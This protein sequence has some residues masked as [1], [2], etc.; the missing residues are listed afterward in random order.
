MNVII[1]KSQSTYRLVVPGDHFGK[2][3]KNK[4]PVIELNGQVYSDT[5]RIVKLLKEH[6]TDIDADLSP[7][8]QATSLAIIRM[9][10]EHL[11]WIF[12]HFRWIEENAVKSFASL[13][14]PNSI[15]LRNVIF[16]FIRAQVRK[17]LWG[18]GLGRHTESD[19]LQFAR[20]DLKSLETLLGKDDFFFGKSKPHLVDIVVHSIISMA[21]DTEEHVKSRATEVVKEYKT[22]LAFRDRMNVLLK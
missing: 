2:T 16:P 10:E 3:P 20:D 8:E 7:L 21:L 11:Y 14:M 4:L 6:F 17:S 13:I 5:D 22:L 18:H 9:A 12:V 1:L 19:M 15:F